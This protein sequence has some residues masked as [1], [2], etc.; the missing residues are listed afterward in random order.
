MLQHILDCLLAYVLMGWPI[1]PCRAHGDKAKAP[2]TAHG[3]KDASLDTEQI[4]TWAVQ[5]PD[6][7]W[8]VATAS[9]R[10]V[11][12]VDPRNG[13]AESLARLVAEYGPLPPTPRVRTGSGGFHYW[14]RCPEG[15]SCGKPFP[16]IDR[17]ADG[18]YVIV[19]PSEIAITEHEGR[20][21]DWEI[22][23]WDV[24]IAE[25]P[26]W[27]LTSKPTN[28][29]AEGKAEAPNPWIV[30]ASCADLLTHPGSPEG[31]RRKT[32]C[33]LAGVHLARGDSPAT[34]LALAEAWAC[35]CLPPLPLA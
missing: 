34:V 23:P 7:A 26:A 27:L 18:G 17:K 19:P 31:E 33:R 1:F 5:Y 11:L 13:G 16:G 28:G 10:A 12:D 29:K 32:L 14:L 6:C 15:T 2:Y 4:K 25:A 21:Y 22:R 24:A 35:R 8:A 20:A 3:H 30:Q 9:S